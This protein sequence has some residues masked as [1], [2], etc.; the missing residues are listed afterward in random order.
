[1]T[2]SRRA[3]L[4]LAAAGG[5][6]LAAGC[7]GSGGPGAGEGGDGDDGVVETSSVTMTGSQF[8]PRNVHVDAGATV[9][10]TN[11]D[12]AAHTVTSASGN[13]DMDA[14][15]AG[16]EE[17]THTFEESGVYDVYCSIHG[18]EDLS[19]MSMKVGVGDA[20]IESPLGGSDS[21]GGGYG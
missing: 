9:T 7:A 3:V 10:W 16:G 13:W 11:A 8:D 19:G 4:S 1:M 17:V 12:A 20:A 21:E 15:V 18:S 5:L 14:E 6:A 2:H